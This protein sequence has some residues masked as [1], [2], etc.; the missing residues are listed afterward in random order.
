MKFYLQDN[1]ADK[2]DDIIKRLNKLMDGD[3]S[4][5]MKDHGIEYR[6]NYGASIVWLRSLAKKYRYDN[7]LADRL[8]QRDIRE[9]MI[10]ASMVADSSFDINAM[11]EEWSVLIDSNEISEQLGVNLLW[12]IDNVELLCRRW[13]KD[14]NKYKNAAAWV[15][16]AVFMQKGNALDEG[17]LDSYFKLIKQS[18]S[19]TGKFT[20]RVQGRFLRQL[21]RK[22]NDLLLRV[23]QFIN[24][25]SDQPNCAWLVEDVKTELDF[26]KHS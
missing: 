26:M 6:L 5:Q 16:L 21:C 11:L 23:E 24:E 2:V 10:L 22:S 19:S 12:R 1:T 18:F 14:S 13:L 4:S 3:V 20:L 9:T 17:D 25:V 8:W 15:G 7:E